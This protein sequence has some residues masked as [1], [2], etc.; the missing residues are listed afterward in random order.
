[1]LADP[2]EKIEDAVSGLGSRAQMAHWARVAGP[3]GPGL[4]WHI[5]QWPQCLCGPLGPGHKA[6][7]PIGTASQGPTAHVLQ[8]NNNPKGIKESYV[9][10][11]SL[12]DYGH[13]AFI[14]IHL[15]WHPS[16]GGHGHLFSGVGTKAQ[17]V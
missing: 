17:Y 11:G 1:M 9:Y 6:H 12:Q 4:I 13:P 14:Y 5:G 3:I 16:Q 2:V 7:W 15:P 8:V 10:A